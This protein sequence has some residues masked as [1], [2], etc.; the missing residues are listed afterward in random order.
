MT[1][2]VA[3]ADAALLTAL[4]RRVEAT[5]RARGVPYGDAHLL[6]AATARELLGVAE[7]LTR[8]EV[9]RAQSAG[10]KAQSSPKRRIAETIGS[11][12]SPFGVSSYST[13][14]GD[15]G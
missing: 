7:T 15:S 13:R 14:G 8:R 4:R 11:S 9:A 12:A 6:A 2:D 3:A 10:R 5:L 1:D